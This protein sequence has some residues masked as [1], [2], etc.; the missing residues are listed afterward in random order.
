[1]GSWDSQRHF[2]IWRRVNIW[3]AQPVPFQNRVWRTREAAAIEQQH[4]DLCSDLC[5]T[6]TF[7]I[8]TNVFVR[9]LGNDRRDEWIRNACSHIDRKVPRSLTIYG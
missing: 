3:S 7:V 2:D 9:F 4:V 8:Q 1:M 6:D 5:Q